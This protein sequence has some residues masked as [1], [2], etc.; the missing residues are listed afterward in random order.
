MYDRDSFR[1]LDA[2]LNRA[3]EALRVIE[4]HARFA[5]DDR[6]AASATKRLRHELRRIVDE[7]G[8]DELL[9]ARDIVSD[10]G[11]DAKTTSELVRESAEDVVRA[12]F[13]RLQEATR[14]LGEY[15]KIV[16]PAAAV[17]AEAIRY[18]AYALEQRTVLRGD[19]RRRF[20][21]VRLYTIVT[22]A[23]CKGDWLETAEAA[24]AG[25][26][27]CIQ[28]REKGLC[29]AELLARARKLRELTRAKGVLFVVN[30]RADIARLAAADG[31]HVG[32][33]D[34]SVAD[35]RRIVGG[36]ALVGKSTHTIEQFEAAL[37]E[38]P[39]YLAV[40]PMF[41]ST[42]KPQEHVAGPE[43]LAAARELTDLPIVAIGGITLDNAGEIASGGAGTLAVCSAV[44]GAQDAESAAASIAAICAKPACH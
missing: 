5:L 39:D 14:V 36:R 20:R 43:T 21:A 6:D 26:A 35:A 7:C 23:M 25:G 22:A 9:S 1:I 31:V 41:Q 30:D 4:D 44:I 34:L 13:A 40:G 12:A 18:D 17:I 32:Q 3:R 28:I 38:N 33:D 29:D 24:I 2:N 16:A 10:V 11:R 8:A 42:T 19:L 27:T 37:D 15:A